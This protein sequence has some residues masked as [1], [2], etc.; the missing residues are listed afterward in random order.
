MGVTKVVITSNGGGATAAI[1]VAIGVMFVTTVTAVNSRSA[2][3]Y[4][5]SGGAQAAFFQINKTTGVLTFRAPAVAGTYAVTVAA[6]A[7]SGGTDTQA[8]AVTVPSALDTTAPMLSGSTGTQLADTTATLSVV[9]NEATGRWYWIVASLAPA[10]TTT[11]IK[12]GQKSDGTLAPSFGS[13]VVSAAGLQTT[14]AGGVPA[15]TRYAYFMHEDAASN[16]SLVASS[17]A[18]VQTVSAGKVLTGDTA[19][20]TL[21]DKVGNPLT[22]A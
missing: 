22:A 12:V 6:K 9:S 19:S 16:Q 21:T 2:I 20:D 3:S 10:P 13:K 18:W 4:S 14:T 11:Q 5:I 15:G 8:I 1:T 17:A 7:T